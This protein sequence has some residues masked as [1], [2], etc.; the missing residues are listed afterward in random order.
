MR[1]EKCVESVKRRS[2]IPIAFNLGTDAI[3]PFCEPQCEMGGETE[4]SLSHLKAKTICHNFIG[5]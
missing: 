3:F 4:N 5:Y 2:Q 1:T